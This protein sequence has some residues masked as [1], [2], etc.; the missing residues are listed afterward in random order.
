M[1]LK[2]ECEASIFSFAPLTKQLNANTFGYHKE[3][4]Q[5]V[6]TLHIDEYEAQKAAGKTLFSLSDQTAQ[7]LASESPF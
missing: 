4:V 5:I 1:S 3:F 7:F 2:S 6:L